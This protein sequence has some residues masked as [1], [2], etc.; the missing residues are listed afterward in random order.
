M[1]GRCV[2]H[3]DPAAARFRLAS[4]H[5]GQTAAEVRDATG[6]DYDGDDAPETADPTPAQLAL[7]RGPVCAEMLDTYP[8]FCSRVWGQAAG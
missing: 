3:F 6:F 5:P 2:F 8:E 4:V 7:L 1:T